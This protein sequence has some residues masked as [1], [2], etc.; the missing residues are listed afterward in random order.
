MADDGNIMTHGQKQTY[1]SAH[2]T[3]IITHAEV[4]YESKQRKGA[5]KSFNRPY[6]DTRKNKNSVVEQ[7][8]T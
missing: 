2:Q 6:T 3:S 1:V 5:F 8:S 7:K 4:F